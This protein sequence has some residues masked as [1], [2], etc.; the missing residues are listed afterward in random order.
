MQASINT[1][2]ESK[3]C[4]LNANGEGVLLMPAHLFS[5]I[6]P[7][8]RRGQPAWSGSGVNWATKFVVG[9]CQKYLQS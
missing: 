4:V 8:Y 6:V 2:L 3:I 9:G 1:H 5:T 7:R